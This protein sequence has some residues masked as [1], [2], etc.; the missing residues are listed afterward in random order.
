[1]LI[2]SSIF[3]SSLVIVNIGQKGKDHNKPTK[4]HQVTSYVLEL[5]KVDKHSRN[6]HKLKFSMKSLTFSCLI[7]ALNL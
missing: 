2:K 1:M 4:R 7:C 5:Q 3:R 6:S